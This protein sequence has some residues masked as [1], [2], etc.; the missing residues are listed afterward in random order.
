MEPLP[1]A[2]NQENAEKL[3]VLSEKLVGEKFEV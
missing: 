1:Y 3:W 2:N